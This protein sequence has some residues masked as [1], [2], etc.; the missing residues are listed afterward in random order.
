MKK[1]LLIVTIPL[2]VIVL[3]IAALL[4]FVDPNQ[5]KPLIVEQTK[6]HTGMDLVVEGDISWR[7]FPSLGLSLGQTELRNPSGFKHEN[8]LKIN[9]IDV[10]VSV[11]PL[12]D[13]E[14][15][16]G[17]ILLDGAEIY[18]ET[19]KDGTSNLDALT[20]SSQPDGS[21][22]PSNNT[23]S[24][25]NQ[26][27]EASP[28]EDPLKTWSINLAGVSVTN[29]RLEIQDDKAGNHTQLYDVGLSV[30]QFQF[31]QWSTAEFEAKGKN[32][33]QT[34]ATN[35][36]L[37]IKLSAD[38]ASYQLRNIVVDS[39]FNDPTTDIS[40]AKVELKTFDFDKA[41]PLT[42]TVK[43][44]AANLD[45]DLQLASELLV[46]KAISQIRLEKMALNSTFSGASLPQNPMKITADSNLGFDTKASLL[47]VGLNKLTLN[48]IQLDGKAT[49]KLLDIPQVRFTLHSPDINLDALWVQK[50]KQ[51]QLI[52][53]KKPQHR[54]R[55][56]ISPKVAQLLLKRSLI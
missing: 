27:T 12:L 11:M 38:M 13:N 53:N 40:S 2:L 28:A 32:N 24:S 5:F 21:A 26:V 54:H 56:R 23:P 50:E 31:D 45:I 20:K 17:N 44:H 46:D 1:L 6:K 48:D 35:G 9:A 30:S 10:D 41:N 15:Y 14:L 55:E 52:Q 42:V 8:L 7:F 19:K 29:A 25:E 47:S 34:F 18:L 39:R 49:V 33:Q 43:G 36:G 37:E 16:I 4:F 3:A 22:Q 51:R